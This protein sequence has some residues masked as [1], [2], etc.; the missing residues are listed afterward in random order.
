MKKAPSAPPPSEPLAIEK[1]EKG[2]P[3]SMWELLLQLRVLL[4]YLTRIVPLLERLLDRSITAKQL[5]YG[6]ISENITAIQTGS[7]DLEVQARNQALQ[8]ENLEQQ[9]VRMRTALETGQQEDRILARELKSEL[10]ELGRRLTLLASAILVLLVALTVM[11]VILLVH[12]R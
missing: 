1:A 8:I 6:A 10:G 3:R 9:I 4:P 2:S 12:S 7:R 11:I 5:D